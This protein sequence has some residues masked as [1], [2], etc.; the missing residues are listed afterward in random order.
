[1]TETIKPLHLTLNQTKL[2]F[3]MSI[4]S[5][6]G[7]NKFDLKHHLRI[8][9]NLIAEMQKAADLADI[10]VLFFLSWC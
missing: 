3:I 10:S 7:K 6:I 1:M 9:L 2:T 5:G 4:C 8:H